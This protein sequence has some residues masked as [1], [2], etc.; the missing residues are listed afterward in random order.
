MKLSSLTLPWEVESQMAF[1][2]AQKGTEMITCLPHRFCTTMPST[3]LIH[4]LTKSLPAL[5]P[6]FPFFFKEEMC[7]HTAKGILS[8]PY[9]QIQYLKLF[10]PTNCFSF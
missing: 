2:E 5:Q 6:L 7:F 1:T 4:A 9:I 10:F 3:A 8:V